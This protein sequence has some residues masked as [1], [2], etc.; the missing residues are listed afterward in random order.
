[1]GGD[2][3]GRQIRSAVLRPAKWVSVSFPPI[4]PQ[5]RRSALRDGTCIY[6]AELAH[7]ARAHAHARRYPD[8]GKLSCA[9]GSRCGERIMF[10]GALKWIVVAAAMVAT[11]LSAQ[12]MSR[13]EP[14]RPAAAAA[15][16]AAGI[17]IPPP[18]PQGST[19]LPPPV[20][21]LSRHRAAG[22]R[23][24]LSRGQACASTRPVIGGGKAR[25]HRSVHHHR[26][27]TDRHATHQYFSRRTIHQCHRMTYRQIVRHRHCR[28][29]MKQ[30][31]KA[32]DHRRHRAHRHRSAH[33]HRPH[34]HR[35]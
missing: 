15:A 28:T 34:R 12:Q 2:A 19:E 14:G 6:S 35:R 20:S 9:N 7:R 13:G 8:A 16:A 23:P 29:M 17:R 11:P 21:P 24:Q 22:A 30:D 5:A 32:S 25:H 31:L 1:M 27:R 18:V 10:K 26:G 3:P 33:P 4:L